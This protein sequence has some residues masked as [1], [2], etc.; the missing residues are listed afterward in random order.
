MPV[1]IDISECKNDEGIHVPKQTL[2][3]NL[4]E[5][6]YGMNRRIHLQCL[7]TT[8]FWLYMPVIL[9]ESVGEPQTCEA[10]P[11]KWENWEN[12][13]TFDGVKP[14]Y[15]TRLRCVPWQCLTD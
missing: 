2:S 12:L 10:R 9:R 6:T 11:T 1:D 14:R 5:E 13:H 8:Q 3:D 4:Q 7:G 15:M